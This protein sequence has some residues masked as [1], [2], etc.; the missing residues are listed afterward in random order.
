ML[1]ET[2]AEKSAP[3]PSTFLLP[4]VHHNFYFKI[5]WMSRI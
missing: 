3:E 1:G 5:V 4:L 2:V